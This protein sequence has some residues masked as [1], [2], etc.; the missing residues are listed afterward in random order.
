[1]TRTE[2]NTSL[3]QVRGFCLRK[4]LDGYQEVDWM[5][6]GCVLIDTW[7]HANGKKTRGHCA[8]PC[9]G[10]LF[11]NFCVLFRTLHVSANILLLRWHAKKRKYAQNRAEMCR[12]HFYAIPLQLYPLSRVT[13]I[14]PVTAPQVRIYPLRI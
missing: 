1:M 3:V 10:A 5:H 4:S 2:R 8:R 9:E 14:R 12:K 11:A 13:E 6:P 7:A